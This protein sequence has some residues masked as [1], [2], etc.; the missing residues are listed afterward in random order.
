M[1]SSALKCTRWSKVWCPK[2]HAALYLT[3]VACRPSAVVDDA[4]GVRPSDLKLAACSPQTLQ[5]QCAALCNIPVS[6]FW[7]PKRHAALLTACQWQAASNVAAANWNV[8]YASGLQPSWLK[9]SDLQP[10]NLTA[11]ICSISYIYF[12]ELQ[13]SWIAASGVEPSNYTAVACGPLQHQLHLCHVM[14]LSWI[15][16]S[17]V[18]SSNYTAAV[19]GPLQHQ[20]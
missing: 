19:C 10:S 12:N 8:N 3:A 16:A 2:R 5:Q 20:L 4:S 6:I 7:F 17:G 9:A 13:P 14:Q 15:A 1:A 11:A 18:E